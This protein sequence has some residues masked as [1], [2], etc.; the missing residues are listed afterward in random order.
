MADTI[1]GV[2]I[3]AA[4]LGVYW[5]AQNLDAMPEIKKSQAQAQ[6]IIAETRRAEIDLENK[7]VNLELGKLA[8]ESQRLGQLEHTIPES[9]EAEYKIKDNTTKD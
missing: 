4:I 6:R 3:I 9:T 1:I 8:L 5:L 7:K 2:I